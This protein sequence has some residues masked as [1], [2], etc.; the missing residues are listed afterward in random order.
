LG[1][2]DIP[3]TQ[4]Y[5]KY[6]SI[7]LNVWRYELASSSKKVNFLIDEEISSE[8]ERLIPSGKR[9]RFVNEALRKELEL[10]RRKEAARKLASAPLTGRK[11]TTKQILGFLSKDRGSH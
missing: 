9:S 2:V 3:F 5:R 6:V 4:V 10:A 8:L 7:R 1:W 11:L